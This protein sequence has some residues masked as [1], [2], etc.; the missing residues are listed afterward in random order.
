MI[1]LN[2]V[3]VREY[4]QK[5][6]VYEN[7]DAYSSFSMQASAI[8][9]NRA[10][11]LIVVYLQLRY[12]FNFKSMFLCVQ[13]MAFHLALDGKPVFTVSLNHFDYKVLTFSQ[14]DIPRFRNE[15]CCE[16]VHKQLL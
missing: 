6:H 5:R 15:I 12:V 14:N 16:I 2:F 4:I 1:T 11:V 9:Q 7:N 10:M 13:Q 3:I 8:L